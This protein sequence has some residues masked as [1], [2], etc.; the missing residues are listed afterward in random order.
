MDRQYRHIAGTASINEQSDKQKQEMH[1]GCEFIMKLLW[2]WK[3]DNG[4]KDEI[5]NGEQN[6]SRYIGRGV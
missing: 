1:T 3:C 6:N 5:G 4:A 2:A